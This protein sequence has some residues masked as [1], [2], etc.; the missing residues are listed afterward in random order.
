MQ[1][2]PG[3]HPD[4]VRAAMDAVAQWQFAETLLNCQPIEIDMTVRISFDP[5]S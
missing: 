1:P 5:A 2:V 3:E 4:L